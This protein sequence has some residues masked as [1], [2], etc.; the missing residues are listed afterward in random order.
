MY[1]TD[2]TM[3]CVVFIRMHEHEINYAGTFIS[4]GWIFLCVDG[5]TISSNIM[6]N[7]AMH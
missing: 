2:L 7:I 5:I 1:Y 3:S 6:E 4:T